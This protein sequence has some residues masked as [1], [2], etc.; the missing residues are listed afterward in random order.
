[1]SETDQPRARCPF[2]RA[3]LGAAWGARVECIA[4]KAPH[5]PEC[6]VESQGCA[7][8]GCRARE[9]IVPGDPDPVPLAFLADRLAKGESAG[10]DLLAARLATAGG[11]LLV[12]GS[13]GYGIIAASPGM[14]CFAI[15]AAVIGTVGLLAA[16]GLLVA[17]SE[18]ERHRDPM[19]PPI[20]DIRSG[21]PGIGPAAVMGQRDPFDA[22][23]DRLEPEEREE[24]D[25]RPEPP[26]AP[27]TLPA[28]CP[29]CANA[30]EPGDPGSEPIAFC[31]HCGAP[32]A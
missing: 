11:V 20:D 24:P 12:L 30:L 5:H 32:L 31:Y 13:F 9:V 29:S 15:A 23:R 19:G 2:C 21:V 1:V 22:I 28:K 26:R 3:E 27:A 6:F 7:A 10:G 18:Q 16:R 25:E 8:T 17:V 4:C 14:V